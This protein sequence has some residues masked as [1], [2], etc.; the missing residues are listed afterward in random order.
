MVTSYFGIKLR[1]IRK[2]K[3]ISERE[4]AQMLAISKSI[5]SRWENGKVYPQVIWIYKIADK[6][7][8]NPSE[9]V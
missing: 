1:Q 4:L 6:L 3:G 5:I 2:E 7:S 9:L 8:I